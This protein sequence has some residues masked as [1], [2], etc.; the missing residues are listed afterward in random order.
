[1]LYYIIN[2]HTQ[3]QKAYCIREGETCKTEEEQSPRYPT[4]KYKGEYV[5]EKGMCRCCIDYLS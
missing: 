3:T 2:T 1:M 4:K 5:D